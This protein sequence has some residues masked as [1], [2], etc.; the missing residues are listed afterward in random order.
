MTVQEETKQASSYFFYLKH[1]NAQQLHNQTTIPGLSR[2]IRNYKHENIQFFLLSLQFFFLLNSLPFPKRYTP[3]YVHKKKSKEKYRIFF[4]F[5]KW[6][7][8]KFKQ[9]AAQKEQGNNNKIKLIFLMEKRKE[10]EQEKHRKP[11]KQG[12]KILKAFFISFW[13]A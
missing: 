9:I 11:G 7:I 13:N 5:Y 3:D 12:F 2:K 4:R 6:S 8:N 10:Q 1:N